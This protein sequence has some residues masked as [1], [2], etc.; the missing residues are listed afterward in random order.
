MPISI[1]KLRTSPLQIGPVGIRVSH[2]AIPHFAHDP[3]DRVIQNIVARNPHNNVW[4]VQMQTNPAGDTIYLPYRPAEI[5]SIRLPANPGAGGATI[6]LTANLDG[7]CMFLE[8]KNNGDI[9]VYHANSQ[10]G[11]PTAQ[12]SATMPTFQ[13][14]ACLADLDAMYQAAR[15]HYN[16]TP[17]SMQVALKKSRYLRDVGHRLAHKTAQGRTGHQFGGTAEHASFTTFAGFFVANRWEF[18]FQTYSQFIYDRPAGHIKSRFG[19]RT[20]DPDAT[21]DDFE[22]IE[23]VRYFRA[24]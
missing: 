19:H 23:A 11:V 20:V 22:I 12:Q 7:C 8:V 13:T 9:I 24:P 6:F 18:W 5:H 2:T 15:A 4:G 21:H 10:V 17:T 16:G 1:N 14:P 3:T